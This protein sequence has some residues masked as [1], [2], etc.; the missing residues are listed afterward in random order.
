MD[1]FALTPEE[2]AAI[3]LSLRVAT[4]A[5]VTTLPFGLALAFLL[6]RYEFWGKAILNGII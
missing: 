5:M 3:R 4:V 6:A 2:W 1:W